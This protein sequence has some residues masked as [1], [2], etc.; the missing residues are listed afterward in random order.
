MTALAPAM[1][2]QN[3]WDADVN[4]TTKETE[5]DTARKRLE[6]ERKN[7]EQTR[8][9]QTELEE[10]VQQLNQEREALNRRLIEG[11]ARIQTSEAAMS[12]IEDRLKGLQADETASRKALEGQHATIARLLAVLQRM[13]RNPPPVMITRR[14][15]ALAQVRSAMVL[16]AIFPQLREKALALATT[17]ESLDRVV[18][19]IREQGQRLSEERI[20]LAEE[21][22][23]LDKFLVVKREEID[24]SETALAE[25]RE[26]AKVQAKTVANLND[27]IR[28]LDKAVASKGT[29]GTYEKKLEEGTAPGQQAAIPPAKTAT[30]PA[31]APSSTAATQSSAPAAETTPAEP[32]QS[33]TVAL[34]SASRI[35]PAMPFDKAKGRLPLPAQGKRL[36]GFGQPTKY[37][38]RAKGIA[39]A[40]RASAQIVSPNDGWVVYA[41]E[42]RSYGQIL[43]INAGGGYHVLLAGM[44]QISAQVGQFVLSGEPVGKMGEKQQAEEDGSGGAPILY[45][46]FRKQERPIDP[47]PWWSGDAE[48]AQG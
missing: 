40:T 19:D 27:L 33:Q 14:D 47:D 30:A 7:L 5:K 4:D 18:A 44:K 17:L 12:R 42:F 48:K 23:D 29:L 46:E 1:L 11:A 24:K 45:I 38:A 6:Q 34:L 16:A 35:E 9:H 20:R 10:N 8:Q 21:Q 28:K 41:G 15:D 2:A 25:L 37:E 43:I 3:S 36:F 22:R 32:P 39:L 26:Q 31:A 13:G